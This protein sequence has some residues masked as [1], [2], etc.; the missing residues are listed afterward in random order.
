MAG[1]TTAEL[2]SVLGSA[3]IDVLAHND[4]EIVWKKKDID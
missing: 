1:Y 3:I 2:A 4:M